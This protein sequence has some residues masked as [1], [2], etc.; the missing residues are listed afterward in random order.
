[1]NFRFGEQLGRL[2]WHVFVI[3]LY[4]SK[5]AWDQMIFTWSHACG[6]PQFLRSNSCMLHLLTSCKCMC[7]SGVIPDFHF[8]MNN[9]TKLSI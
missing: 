4:I 5:V 2:F 8:L 7:F 6:R 1:M 3:L 9:K